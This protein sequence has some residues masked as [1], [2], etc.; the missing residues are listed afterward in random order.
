MSRYVRNGRGAVRPFVYGRLDLIDFVQNVFDPVE[1]ERNTIGNGFHIQVQIGDSVIVLSAMEP[2]FAEATR[3]SL[4]VY[5]DDVDAAYARA[6][7]AG[8]TSLGKPSDR[9]FQERTASVRD[10]FGNVWYLATYTGASP[11]PP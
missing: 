6:I 10:T 11:N 4:Y 9:P 5:V 2:P 7:A 1:L 3:A 8:A